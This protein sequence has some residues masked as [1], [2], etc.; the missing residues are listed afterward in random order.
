MW[1][2]FTYDLQILQLTYAREEECLNCGMSVPLNSLKL[3]VTEC[4]SVKL[5]ISLHIA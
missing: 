4:W 3:H 1:F 2:T 5:I